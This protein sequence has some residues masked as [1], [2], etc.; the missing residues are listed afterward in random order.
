MTLNNSCDI[1]ERINTADAARNGQKR[2]T[3]VV[4]RA[5]LAI[6]YRLRS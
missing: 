2:S 5:F 1:N 3:N 4:A 6:E